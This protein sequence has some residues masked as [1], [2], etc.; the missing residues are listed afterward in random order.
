MVLMYPRTVRVRSS[1]G[2]I[3][4][5]VR[6]VEACREGGKVKQR[7]IADLGRKDLLIDI[8]PKLKRLLSGDAAPQDATAVDPEVVDA[9]TW[10]PVLVIRALFGQLGLWEILDQHLGHAKGVPFADRG[11]V[12]VADRLIAPASEH[13][14]AGWLETDFVCDRQGRRFVPHWHRRRRVRVHPRQLDAWYR[15]LDQLHAAK[16]RIEVALYHRLRDLFSLKPDLVLYDI[17]STYFEGAGP[18][19]FAK[20]GYSRDGKSQDVQVIVGVVMVAGWPIAHHVWAGNRIDHST[21]QEVIDDLRKRFEFGRLVFVGD[22]GMVTDEN[23]EQITKD[24]HG[25]LV[26]LKRRRN[27]EL[28]TWLD[29]LDETRWIDCPGG[30]DAR[31]RK[32][33]PAR[34]RAQEVPSGDPDRRVIVIDSDERRGYEQ[35]KREQAME[36]AREK[37]EKL[38]GRVAAGDLKQPEKIGAAVAR[39]MQ[40]YHGY[41]Y[42]DWKLDAGAFVYSESEGRLGREKKIEGKYVISTSEKDLSILEAVARYEE[43]MVVE[44][45]FRQLKDVLAMRPIYHQIE[46]RV[47]AHIFVA[48]LALLVQRL[49]G[50]RLEESGLDLSP[51]RALQALSTVRLVRFR[52]E[53]Q[54]DRRGVSGG[55]PD[56]RS[57]LKALKLIDQR[58]PV[59]PEGEETVMEDVHRGPRLGSAPDHVAPR[60]SC[61]AGW[62]VAGTRGAESPVGQVDASIHPL[63]ETV[64]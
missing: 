42:F 57:V 34:T 13:G 30:I 29:A 51:E 32:T 1:S 36:R 8:L 16:E 46:P 17:T 48:A 6:I 3:H 26:G 52:L 61:G 24:E 37:L 49:L 56:A 18:D 60:P 59:P 38:K 9:S 31:E 20:H 27:P 54:G 14:L 35:A 15:T 45:G 43:L 28:D 55:C 2:T 50:R 19:N 7:V 63:G 22:R 39:I 40:K 12:L 23:I 47:K 62:P 4:E 58:P 21:V 41:R 53:G 10:G 11:F 5:Y 64:V 44:S 33:D 25:F